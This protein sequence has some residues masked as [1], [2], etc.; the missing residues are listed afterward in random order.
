MKVCFQ[1]RVSLADHT[2]LGAEALLRWERPDGSV[3]YPGD[4]IPLY[5]QT[6]RILELDFYVLEKIAEFLERC[7][8]EGKK[9]V[10]ISINFSI[11]H[12]L[13]C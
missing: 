10:P 3:M 1:P 5:E 12:P 4:F 7:I 11:L 13:V 2:M 6:G 9:V 8:R